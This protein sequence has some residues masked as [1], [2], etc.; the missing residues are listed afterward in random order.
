MMIKLHMLFLCIIL[1]ASIMDKSAANFTV[2]KDESKNVDS[3][4]EI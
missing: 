1:L 4:L 3:K 2:V